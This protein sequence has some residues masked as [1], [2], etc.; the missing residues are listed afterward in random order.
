M[1]YDPDVKDKMRWQA[2]ITHDSFNKV[3]IIFVSVFQNRQ[4]RL[5]AS[6]VNR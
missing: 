6:L 2:S 5:V 4:N 1:M 3:N